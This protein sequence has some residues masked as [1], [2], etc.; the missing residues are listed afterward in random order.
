[1]TRSWL[2]AS[3]CLVLCLSGCK[4][5]LE[6]REPIGVCGDGITQTLAGEECDDNNTTPGDKCSATCTIEVCGN[7]TV[8]HGEE[9]DD[10][11][12]NDN[13]GDCTRQCRKARCGDG[14][15]KN[16]GDLPHEVCDDGN[17]V[18][19]DGCNPQCGLRGRTGVLFG[20][21]G[22]R[23][24]MNGVGGGARVSGVY[25]LVNDG[26][27]LYFWDSGACSIR[28]VE[29][30]SGRIQ[31]IAGI[32]GACS[33]FDLVKDGPGDRATFFGSGT[34]V[35][36]EDEVQLALVGQTL[37]VMDGM[38]VLRTVDLS[39]TTRPVQTCASFAKRG[40]VYAM[41]A[42]PL[43]PGKLYVAAGEAQT[44]LSTVYVV[45][46][47]CQC[48]SD[49]Q[50]GKCQV[51]VVGQPGGFPNIVRDMEIVHEG[52]ETYLYVAEISEVHRVDLK[53]GQ[54]ESV[55]G[56]AGAAHLDAAT[57][58]DARF[59]RIRTLSHAPGDGFYVVQEDM[60][61]NPQNPKDITGGPGW[62]AL[63]RIDP[64]KSFAVTTAAGSI[65][66]V[67]DPYTPETDGFGVA[68]R[69]VNPRS[70]TVV[71]R[72]L[73][74][75]EDA[76]IR[77]VNLDSGQVATV[78]GVLHRDFLLENPRAVA[79]RAGKVYV[80]TRAGRLL[81]LSVDEKTAPRRVSTCER[82]DG[83]I[84]LDIDGLIATEDDEL[85]Y[86]DYSIGGVCRVH[87]S[88]KDSDG[89]PTGSAGCSECRGTW[90]LVYPPPSLSSKQYADARE[91]F[92]VWNVT[93][94]TYDG[95]R[96]LYLVGQYVRAKQMVPTL[97]P[98]LAG[99][100]RLDVQTGTIKILDTATPLPSTPWG[101]LHHNGQLYVTG[102]PTHVVAR[103]DLGDASG[104]VHTLGDGL[105]GT[106]DSSADG[107][108]RF[109]NPLGINAAAGMIV[110]GEGLCDRSDGSWVGN[111]VRQI[112]PTNDTVTTLLGPGS[113]PYLQAGTGRQASVNR[114]AALAYDS[115]TQSI[116]IADMWSG[117]VVQ[118]D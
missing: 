37:Y 66:R 3:V 75:G 40:I 38:S 117:A 87:L 84:S 93:G 76:S 85:Y 49:L 112:D 77:A 24:V 58:K 83:I 36:R 113:L 70:A 79:A 10:G 80:A 41:A 42:D 104:I 67:I 17:Q 1:M 5:L 111:A 54:K 103:L 39:K 26:K 72:V 89:K 34:G 16:R 48:S 51:D 86:L 96:Y 98:Y 47:P 30:A 28:S 8:D 114:P 95:K 106:V 7:G 2:P 115:V 99:V 13:S 44:F 9:C 25:G 20:A 62:A 78:G 94:M 19:G 56:A 107:G 50:V 102:G 12:G 101:V 59:L 61:F 97:S 31:T 22:G 90:T 109:C 6:S 53:T 32:D 45:S 82:P 81:E 118:V 43:D 57:G 35:R 63:R 4:S 64:A 69:L 88:G 46:L 71:G 105:A 73:Y 116:Y 33:S 18:N 65:G 100:A 15:V 55:A 52:G 21:S 91:E 27:S 29:L 110:V 23:G 108:P 11:L 68:A 60:N 14:F 92:R 74:I